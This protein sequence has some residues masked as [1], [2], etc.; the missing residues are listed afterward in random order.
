MLIYI[1]K[2]VSLF[3]ETSQIVQ[4]DKLL[5]AHHFLV[6][7]FSCTFILEYDSGLIL[8]RCR[9]F[10]KTYINNLFLS[11]IVVRGKIVI[12]ELGPY[13]SL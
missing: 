8:M 9:S 11:T 13:A 4:I 7:V 12:F 5:T 2:L 6:V 1:T 10:C 3:P